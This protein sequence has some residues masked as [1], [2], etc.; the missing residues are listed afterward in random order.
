MK[1]DLLSAWWKFAISAS[2]IAWTAPWVIQA[3]TGRVMRNPRLSGEVDRR[4]VTRMILEKVQAAQEAQWV[5]WR[6]ALASQQDTWSKLWTA[7]LS[8]TGL[9]P[10]ATALRRAATNSAVLAH[11]VLQPTRRR[12]KTNA[13]RL[14][15]RR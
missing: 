13:R 1:N 15:R 14:S 4:E 12:V 2:E 9:A 8:P 5:L 11:R 10:A 3:R 7:G 6:H